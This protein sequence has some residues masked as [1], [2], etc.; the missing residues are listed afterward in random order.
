[1]VG[2]ANVLW[3]MDKT[4]AAELVV[5]KVIQQRNDGIGEDDVLT[6]AAVTKS[7]ELRCTQ[8]R[9]DTALLD[10]MDRIEDLTVLALVS[11]TGMTPQ[12]LLADAERLRRLVLSTG[13]TPQELLADAERLR[14]LVLSKHK[15]AGSASGFDSISMLAKVLL[16]SKDMTPGDMNREAEELFD[17]AHRGQVIA[18]GAMHTPNTLLEKANLCLT[19]LLGNAFFFSGL[20]LGSSSPISSSPRLRPALLLF[21]FSFWGFFGGVKWMVPTGHPGTSSYLTTVVAECRPTGS[22]K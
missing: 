13:M 6:T 4:A 9:G 22:K 18:C 14:R 19:P 8:L 7:A 1:M 17:E 20:G 5:V 21:P 3:T 10:V 11:S 12:E 16:E 15:A 2:F